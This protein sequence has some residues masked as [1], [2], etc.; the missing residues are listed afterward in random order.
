MAARVKEANTK[1]YKQR[2]AQSELLEVRDLQTYRR[3][4]MVKW[5]GI[6]VV[7]VW[8]KDNLGHKNG[9]CLIAAHFPSIV[10]WKA[11]E[12]SESRCLHILLYVAINC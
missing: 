12:N 8:S 10:A 7:T 5:D 3:P 6:P 1:Y 9:W 11:A 4:A 2:S